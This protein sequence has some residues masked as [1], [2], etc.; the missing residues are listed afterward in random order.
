MEHAHREATAAA[1]LGTGNTNITLVTV[2]R[3]GHVIAASDQRGRIFLWKLS[4]GK[5]AARKPVATLVNPGGQVTSLLSGEMRT[6]V[7]SVAFSPDGKTLATS[8][9]NGSTYLWRVR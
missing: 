7:F 2:S 3:N 6:A 9:T 8:D 5:L 1:L 4:A